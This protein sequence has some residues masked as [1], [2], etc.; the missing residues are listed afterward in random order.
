MKRLPQ[1]L[2]ALAVAVAVGAGCRKSPAANAGSTKAPKGD[3]IWLA[4]PAAAGEP[5]LEDALRRIGAVALFLPAGEVGFEGGRWSLH[6]DPPPPRRMERSPVVLVLRAGTGMSGAFSNEE[7]VEVSTMARV[8]GS[9]LTRLSGAGGPY[10]RVIGVHL[11][12]PFSPAGA[13]RYAALLTA[14]RAGLAPGTFIS[15]SVLAPPA[16][17]SDRQKVSALLDA[18]DASVAFVFRDGERSDPAAIDSLRHPWWA[19]FGTAGHG[20]LFPADG[21]ANENVAEQFLDPLSGNPR[22]DLENDLSDNDAAVSAFHARARDAVRLDG[23]ALNRGDLITFRLPSQAELLFQ[24]G[25]ALAGK[26]YALG[27]VVQF[28]GASDAQRTLPLS[29][30]EDVLLGRSLSPELEVEA[31]PGP[32]NAVSV[33]AINRSSH[34][35]IVSRVSNWIEVDL[36]PA[37]PADVSLGGFDRY[38]VYD[39]NG[40]PVSPGRASRVRFFETLIAPGETIA[41]ARIAVRG[42]LPKDCCRHRLRFISAAG[43]ELAVDWSSPPPPPTPTARP[44]KKR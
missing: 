16:A 31:R 42:A 33:G 27:R 12:F 10:G 30:F 18:A 5:G 37:R 19:A 36:G 39:T 9:A 11:D 28:E 38:E 1:V 17:D 44:K 7:G 23:L 43:P 29:A 8:I 40:K 3:A 26:R 25:S 13:P 35:S 20:I 2:L 15:I 32:K 22:V 14:L 24:L 41:P 4:D 34:A 21:K 6:P